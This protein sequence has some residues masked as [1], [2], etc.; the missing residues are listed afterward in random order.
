[1]A[2]EQVKGNLGGKSP[3]TAF[4]FEREGRGYA[5]LWHNS[6]SGKLAVSQIFGKVRFVSELGG[7]EIIS[8]RQA[9]ML[10]LPVGA[11]SY[12]IT[13]NEQSGAS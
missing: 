1:M 4:V 12:L 8:E 9:D 10:I 2:Y 13:R 11:R 5:V 7:K 3:V 6:G